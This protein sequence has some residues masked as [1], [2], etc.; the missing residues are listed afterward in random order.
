[1][2]TERTKKHYEKFRSTIWS[3]HPIGKYPGRYVSVSVD[4][5]IEI[6][7]YTTESDYGHDFYFSQCTFNG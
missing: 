7:I 6:S 2:T 3:V 4:G 1:M 5:K